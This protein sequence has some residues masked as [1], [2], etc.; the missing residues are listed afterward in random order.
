MT[1]FSAVPAHQPGLDQ[2]CIGG[3]VIDEKHGG[4]EI[5]HGL[6]VNS[7]DDFIAGPSPC[8][9]RGRAVNSRS[10]LASGVLSG[11]ER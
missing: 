4:R 6:N 3:I 7:P 1:E 8:P 9:P 2:S 5:V 11:P 10:W